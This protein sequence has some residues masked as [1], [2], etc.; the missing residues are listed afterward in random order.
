MADEVRK[1]ELESL[2]RQV[3]YL[4]GR[5]EDRVDSQGDRIRKLESNLSRLVLGLLLALEVAAIVAAAVAGS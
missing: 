1:W 5:V 2:E 4:E 3:K